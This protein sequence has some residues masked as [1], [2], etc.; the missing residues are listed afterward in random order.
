MRV[1][2]IWRYP[3]KSLGGEPLTAATVDTLGIEGDRVIAVRDEKR[4]E[5]TWAGGVPGLMRVRAV[6]VAP[7]VAELIPPDGERFRSDAP[8]AG[9]RLSAVVDADV[10]L[11]GYQSDRPYAALHV[12]TT[13]TLRNLGSAL[14]DSTV[15]VTRFR[16]NLVLDA[17]SDGIQSGYPELDWVGRRMSIGTLRLRFTEAC[18]RCA[19]IT[20]ETVTAPRDRAVLRFVARELGNAVGVYAEVETP[21]H[22]RVGDEARWL[23]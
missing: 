3:V 18:D 1:D 14:P 22:I 12:L 5:I 23:D 2:Q 9:R 20:R 13:T 11:V 7:G 19:A 10:T 6:T 21:G 17:N 4:D 15:D 16:P 8:D